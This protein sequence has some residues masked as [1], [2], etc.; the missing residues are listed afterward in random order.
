MKRETRERDEEDG[1]NKGEGERSRWKEK[2]E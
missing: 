2:T 1:R